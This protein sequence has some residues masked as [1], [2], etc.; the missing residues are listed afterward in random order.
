MLAHTYEILPKHILISACHHQHPTG[1]T[2]LD[3][4]HANPGCLSPHEES[5][6][7]WAPL[8]FHK[9][10]CLNTGLWDSQGQAHLPQHHSASV[11]EMTS[12][13]STNSHIGQHFKSNNPMPSHYPFRLPSR[14]SLV[15]EDVTAVQQYMDSPMSTLGSYCSS[16]HMYIFPFI[17]GSNLL[18]VTLCRTHLY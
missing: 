12:H 7:P 4:G 9:P 10:R 18:H 14:F 17:V 6:G 5:M 13:N 8:G 16:S 1:Q 15:G 11:T 2:H 3:L